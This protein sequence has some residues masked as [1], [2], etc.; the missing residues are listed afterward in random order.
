V[1]FPRA[2]IGG[3]FNAAAIRP[4]FFWSRTGPYPHDATARDLFI[5]PATLI[6]VFFQ[7]PL[8]LRCSFA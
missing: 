7:L 8:F 3:S 1:G 5:L 2:P 4:F 6:P